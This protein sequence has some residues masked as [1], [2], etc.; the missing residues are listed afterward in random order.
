MTLDNTIAIVSGKGG[1][2]KTA[3]TANLSLALQEMGNRVVAVDCDQDAADLALHLDLE[4]DEDRT[5]QNVM[6]EDVNV[7]DSIALHHTGLMVIPSTHTIDA[8]RIKRSKLKGVIERVN[9]TV[10]IDAPPGL[11]EDVKTIVSVADEVL[12]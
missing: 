3:T 9:G 7:L 10:I 5:L 12:V 2:G 1:V 4:T 6:R 8:E 11:S